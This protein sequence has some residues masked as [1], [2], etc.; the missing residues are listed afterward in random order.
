[1]SQIVIPLPLPLHWHAQDVRAVPTITRRD[2][3][4]WQRLGKGNHA[5]VKQVQ[6][7]RKTWKDWA[8]LKILLVGPGARQG[9]GSGGAGVSGLEGDVEREGQA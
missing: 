7:K 5:E 1:M 2:L 9:V 8:A 6:C 4:W 3:R